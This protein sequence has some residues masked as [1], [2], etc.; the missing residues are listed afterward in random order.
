MSMCKI[1]GQSK[2]SHLIA[3]KRIFKCLKGTPT[4]GFWYPKCSGF[5]LKGYLDSNYVGC[6]MDKKSTSGACQLLG[7]KLVCW[8]AKK[9]QLVVMSSAEV[10]YVVVDHPTSPAEDSEARP[11]KESNIKFIVKNGKMSLILDYKTFCQMTSLEYNNGNYVAHPSIEEVKAELTKINTHDILL[12]MTPLL[13][14]SFPAAWRILMTFVIEVLGGNHSSTELL[15]SSQQLIVYS[16]LT[17]TK[18]DTREIIY[19]DLVTRLMAN[20][21]QKYVSYPRFISCAL[22]RLLGSDYPQDHKFGSIPLVG[23]DTPYLLAGY[24]VL[25]QWSFDSSKSWIR[26]IVP[27]LSIRCL[28]PVGKELISPV[29]H[30]CL[31][32]SNLDTMHRQVTLAKGSQFLEGA[33]LSVRSFPDCCGT[34]RSW[35]YVLSLKHQNHVFSSYLDLNLVEEKEGL[36]RCGS[37][38]KKEKAYKKKRYAAAC[39]LDA[40]LFLVDMT[41]E[42]DYIS[43]SQSQSDFYSNSEGARYSLNWG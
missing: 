13:K 27:F 14:V 25:M 9:Q 37:S 28:K 22:Q 35:W 41:V 30:S 17:R 12:H 32:S 21:R 5:D 34:G 23:T 16:L 6:N 42:D 43:F 31:Y 40:F 10:E 26:R 39:R 33:S 8:S 24:G 7:G 4:L 15:N 18:I 29:C 36:D 20:S 19:N 1:L 3:V 2:E 38:E 11:L